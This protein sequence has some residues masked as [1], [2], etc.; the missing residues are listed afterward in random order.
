MPQDYRTI[1]LEAYKKKRLNREL[2]LNLA[3]PTVGNLKKEC[4]R[5]YDTRYEPKDSDIL[6]V[7][8]NLSGIGEDFRSK[9]S[10]TS[11]GVFKALSNHLKG[12]RAK[13]NER[14]TDLLAWLI[15]FEQRPSF[16][17]YKW[18]REKEEAEKAATIEAPTTADSK[19]E[20]IDITEQGPSFDDLKTDDQEEDTE[21]K[22]TSNNTNNSDTGTSTGERVGDST[23]E[24]EETG[25][26]VDEAAK[27]QMPKRDKIIVVCILLILA[28]GFI[29]YSLRGRTEKTSVFNTLFLSGSEKCMYWVGDHYEVIA[30]DQK[31]KVG[32]P[33]I[34]LNQA[35][36]N[37]LKRI[38]QPDTLT[39]NSIGKVWYARFGGKNEFFTDSGTHP[40]DTAKRLKPITNYIITN[41]TSYH[42]FLLWISGLL[43]VV[44]I[45]VGIVVSKVYKYKKQGSRMLSKSEI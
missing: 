36:L 41:H 16:R 17:Y 33:V 6:T 34:P 39:K 45:L 5:V 8:F 35:K 1:V 26:G 2:N 15:D 3:N 7:F 42:R 18:L 29:G 44:A 20:P 11:E 19:V 25:T 10:G 4:I 27:H 22:D 43:A 28:I 38:T 23:K 31:G 21:N 12:S 30:C 24:E 13:T 40:I 37:N 14:N 32:V 9:L